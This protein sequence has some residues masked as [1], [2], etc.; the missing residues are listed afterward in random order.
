MQIKTEYMIQSKSVEIWSDWM[1]RPILDLEWARTKIN[2]ARI[3]YSNL[4]FRL[5]KRVVNIE[6]EVL[7]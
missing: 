4:T 1:D 7:G 2:N 5:V 6:E 3:Y